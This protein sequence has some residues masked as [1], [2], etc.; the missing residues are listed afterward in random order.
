MIKEL[1]DFHNNWKQF[2]ER[3]QD[4]AQMILIKQRST[5]VNELVQETSKFPIHFENQNIDPTEVISPET[6][7]RRINY[8]FINPKSPARIYNTDQAE[9]QN[10]KCSAGYH[11]EIIPPPEE[12][13]EQSKGNDNYIQM[14]TDQEVQSQGQHGF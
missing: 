13:K 4:R 6:R 14:N 1:Q 8:A 5:E 7:M 3:G 11:V 10:D 2:R 12:E 9:D